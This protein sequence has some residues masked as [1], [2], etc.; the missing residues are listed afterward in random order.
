MVN[1]RFTLAKARGAGVIS[2]ATTS[3][4]LEIAKD[5]LYPD[6]YPEVLGMLGGGLPRRQLVAGWLSGVRSTRRE[7]APCR[8]DA[9]AS[10]RDRRLPRLLGET[11]PTTP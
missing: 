8:D 7:D 4:L 10:H 1:I 5:L 9:E 6:R 2:A 3:A 11:R